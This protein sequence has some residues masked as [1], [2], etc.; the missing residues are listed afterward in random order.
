MNYFMC[1][2]DTPVVETQYGKLRG[3]YFNGVFHFLGIHYAKAKRFEMPEEPD[4][5]E[6]IRDSNSFGNICPTLVK[7][8]P[9]NEIIVPHRYWIE[10]ENCQNLNVWTDTLDDGAK[11]PVMVWFH[12]GGYSDGS[13]IEHIA[14]DGDSLA[15]H[16]G[17][18]VV[19]VNHRLNAFGHMDLSA[20]GEK[21]QNSVNA[22]IA[23]LVAAL[24]W[25]R[26]N[27]A[28]FGGDPDN[29]TIFGQSGGGGKVTTLG[30][31]P[32]ADGLFQKA[33]V[34]SGVFKF[35]SDKREVDHK[36]FALAV[37]KEA[38]IEDGDAQKLAGISTR[39]F[40][41][42][43]N[44]ASRKFQLAGER[45]NWAPHAN[46][47]YLGDPLEA[48]FREHYTKIPTI[49]GTTLA[50]FSRGI[51]VG[52]KDSIPKEERE[53]LIREKLGPETGEKAL[54]AFRKAYPGKNEL[55]LLDVDTMARSAAIEYVKKKASANA[56]PV[57]C[58]QFA[59]CFDY[60]GGRAPWHCAD[61]P[62]FF[63]N[64]ERAPYTYSIPYREALERQMV[65]A[66]VNFAKN[67]DPSNPYLPAWK[68]AAGEKVPTMVFDEASAPGEDYD[69]ALI[70]LLSGTA[71]KLDFAFVTPDEDDMTASGKGWG[72]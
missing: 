38:G 5:W 44:K 10:N 68:P 52:R 23:D 4:R 7:P 67:G 62:F 57:Y 56:A 14:Y 46:D 25:V 2:G 6:G 36:E 51:D 53:K 8:V 71:P 40:V 63:H 59:A 17:V 12:G 11:K 16:D 29:V 55:Y 18:V 31:T 32:A 54:R 43:V 60:M 27:I 42:A 3:Y 30:Q 33:I 64:T 13:A 28:G 47:W 19:C 61:I 20:F 34:M 58:Y 21:Y 69:E 37:M 9:G 65:N 35:R 49:V 15:R 39:M 66:F 48:G 45:I 41:R 22:G 72:Y 70:D 24:K 50:E 1:G 26:N